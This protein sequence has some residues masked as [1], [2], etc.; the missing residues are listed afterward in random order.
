[1][2]TASELEIAQAEIAD[3]LPQTATIQRRTLTDDTA[4]GKVAAYADVSAVACRLAFAGSKDEPT[5]TD[6]AEAGRIVAQVQYV[7]TL[8]ALTEI[9]ATDRLV[10]DGATYELLSPVTVRFDEVS[11]RLLARKL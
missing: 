4:G 9:E 6:R 5:Q 7:I 10:I 11:K 1:M 2:W 3:L 8:P